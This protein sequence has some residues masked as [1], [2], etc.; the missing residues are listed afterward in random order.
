MAEYKISSYTEQK[1]DS[2]TLTPTGRK[3]TK[4]CIYKK[5]FPFPNKSIFLWETVKDNL[6]TK[7]EAEM[8]LEDLKGE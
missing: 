4:Y 3:K 2:R 1:L 8:F 6:K 7:E 5:I